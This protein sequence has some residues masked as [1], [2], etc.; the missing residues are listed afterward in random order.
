MKKQVKHLLLF[1]LLLGC[2]A[3]LFAFQSAAVYRSSDV[4]YFKRLQRYMDTKPV[5]VVDHVVYLPTSDNEGYMVISYFDSEEAMQEATRI[6]IVDEIDGKPVTSVGVSYLD[7]RTHYVFSAEPPVAENVTSIRFSKNTV[8]LNKYTFS[9]LPNLTKYKIPDGIVYLNGAF[10]WLDNLIAITIPASVKVIGDHAFSLCTN[11]KKVVFKG[12]VETIGKY[13]FSRC[14]ALEKLSLPDSVQEIGREAFVASGLKSL[15]VPESCRRITLYAFSGC[16]LKYVTFREV[17]HNHMI[18]LGEGVFQNCT[19]LK[20]VTFPANAKLI[21][22]RDDVFKGDAALRVVLNTQVVR[23][24]G[25]NAFADCAALESFTL[26]SKLKSVHP[27]AFSGCSSLKRVKILTK[28]ADA[29]HVPYVDGCFVSELPDTCRVY[30]KTN[31]MARACYDAGFKG[32]VTV[33]AD[34]K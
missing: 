7:K 3:A 25:A 22:M 11:L 31:A 13:A 8:S 15:V 9:C 20:K 1:A 18:I 26:S 19:G 21:S 12:D 24:I 4:K 2:L 14:T 10:A 17:N 23:E 27:A 34:L 5:Q 6:R 30:V 33:K 29:L 28:K 16:P 32:R